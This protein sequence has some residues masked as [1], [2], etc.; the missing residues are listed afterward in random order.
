MNE[1]VKDYKF[2]EED[3]KK[4]FDYTGITEEKLTMVL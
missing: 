1:L 3:M 4:L 2:N